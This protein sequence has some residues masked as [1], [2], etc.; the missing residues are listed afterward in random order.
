M[1]DWNPDSYLKFKNERTQPSIDL[2]ARIQ[3]HHPGRIIDIGCG[4]GNSTAVLKSRWPDSEV[5]GLD[6]SETM[7]KAAKENYNNIKWLVADASGDLSALGSFDLIFSNA[8][9]QWIPDHHLL[10]PK[11]FDMLS[12]NGSLAVQVPYIEKMPI[13]IG[14]QEMRTSVTWRNYFDKMTTLYRMQPLSFFYDILSRLTNRLDL[15]QTNYIHYMDSPTAIVNWFAAT[16]LRPY[17]D[18]LPSEELRSSFLRDFE[19]HVREAYIPEWN[20]T[21]LFPFTRLFF[22]AEKT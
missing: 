11:L 15:W 20:G 12:E 10:L 7:I 13:H 22:I 17:L 8:A 4:P 3:L 5:L 1:S 2:V 16:G 18:C 9:L 14:L 21:I 6:S 19:N